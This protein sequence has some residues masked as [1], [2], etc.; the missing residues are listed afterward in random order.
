LSPVGLVR[1]KLRAR[2]RR[3]RSSWKGSY[4]GKTSR[5]TTLLRPSLVNL[6]VFMSNGWKGKLKGRC[7]SLSNTAASTFSMPR[8][9]LKSMESSNSQ[10]KYSHISNSWLRM[11]KHRTLAYLGSRTMKDSQ[12]WLVGGPIPNPFES[13]SN[14]F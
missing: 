9:Y 1:L 3:D 7:C 10:C 4:V 8:S 2:R 12:S 6:W 13:D 5:A 11:V 14:L